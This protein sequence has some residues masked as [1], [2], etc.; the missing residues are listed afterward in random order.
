MDSKII[1]CDRCGGEFKKLSNIRRHLNRVNICMPLKNDISIK[2]LKDK[3]SYKKGIYKC[4]NCDKVYKTA[5]GKCKHKKKCITKIMKE[6][7]DN[8]LIYE[9]I[10]TQIKELLSNNY[11]QN[12]TNNLHQNNNIIII[13]NFGE[14]N[15]DYLLNDDNFICNCINSP[16]NSIQQYLDAVHFNNEHPENTNIKLTNLQS[17]FMDYF[18][19]G[20][21]NKVEQRL[22]IPN[23]VQKSMKIIN[24]MIMD[25]NSDE[26]LDYKS[27]LDQKYD[28]VVKNKILMKTKRHIYNKSSE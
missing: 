20:N 18:K 7:V 9:K 8:E 23:I 19:N 12:I 25:E 22:L 27:K 1:E 4:E 15:I 16:I 6:I 21:W 26:W 10:E 28:T 5:V 3:Y 24:K 14:E 2:E 13:N 17:P 11:V